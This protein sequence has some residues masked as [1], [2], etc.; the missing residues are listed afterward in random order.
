[1]LAHILC[2]SGKELLQNLPKTLLCVL[3]VN[4]GIDVFIVISI[5]SKTYFR[6]SVFMKY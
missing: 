2:W 5:M 4:Q 3:V 1:M 6:K